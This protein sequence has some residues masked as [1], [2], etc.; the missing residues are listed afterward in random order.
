M[1]KRL[2]VLA[3][4]AAV[5]LA[6]LN[7][8]AIAADDKKRARRKT[9]CSSRARGKKAITA[10]V[11][12]F[13]NNVAATSA[14]TRALPHARI[15]SDLRSSRAPVDKICQDSGGPCNTRQGHENGSLGYGHH[16]RRFH[17]VVGTCGGADKLSLG[18][19]E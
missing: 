11:D 2:I 6:G 7:T 9:K 3:I 1:R 10:V 14:S 12:E 15:P 13:V 8:Q 18:R 19:L 5:A 4:A 16:R 17:R